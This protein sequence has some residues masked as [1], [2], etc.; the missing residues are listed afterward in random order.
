MSLYNLFQKGLAELR[1]YLNN[2][3]NKGWIKLSM[4][5]VDASILFV[6]KKDEELRLCV[7]YKDLNAIIIKNSHFL[8]LITKMLNRLCKVK[9]FIKLN[10]RNVYHRIQIKKNDEWKTAFRTRYEHFEYHIMSFDLTNAS[11]TFQIYI[12]KALRRLVDVICVICLNDILIFNE[13]STKHRRHVQQVLER[14]KNFELYVNLKKCEFD[15]EEVEFLDF[16]VFTKKIQMN[17]K[18]IQIIKKW[19]K[20]KIY[21]EV[22]IFLKFLNFYKR[23]IYRYF[24]IIASLTSLLKNDEKE[25]K[26]PLKWSNEIE[27]AFRQLKNIFMS[28]SFLIHYDFLK[29]NRV[30]NDVFNFAVAG[31][32]NQQNEN[33][34][35]RSMTFWSRKMIFAEQNYE[36]YD[37]ELLTI[38]VAFKQWR[39]YLKSN[40]YS[41]KVLSDHNSLKRLMTKKELNSRQ[42]RWTQVLATYDFE[43]FHRSSNRNSADD[44]LRRSDYEKISSLKITLLSTLQN[45]LTLSSSE[46]SLTHNERKNSIELIL[47][48]QLTEISIKFDTKLAKLTRNRRNI[49]TELALMFKLIDI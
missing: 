17:S 26:N 2:V 35:W 5:F 33:D 15:M 39:Y 40:F 36:I 25:K 42:A 43:I 14:L 24:K 8:S 16:I 47:V 34:N 1:R 3:L 23:F 7:N 30:K 20:S 10:L 46:K 4:S 49:L 12:N 13:N 44:P 28:I 41:I 37:Q 45:K 38:V 6:L 11:A 19:S 27:Q 22:Q 29:R 48:L 9:R 18:R 21:R 31:D 32:F